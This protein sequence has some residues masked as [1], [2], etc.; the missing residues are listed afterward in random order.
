MNLTLS[1][2]LS[3][4]FTVL[5]LA[6]FGASAWLQVR[7]NAMH[8]KEVVQGLS[9]GL[10]KSIALTTQVMGDDGLQPVAVRR[11]FDQLMIVNPSVEVYLLDPSGRV[12]AHAAP[13]G[14]LKRARVNL[15]PV[16]SL[17]A[18]DMLPILGDDP[19]SASGRKVFSAAV[20]RSGRVIRRNAIRP[21]M[22]PN[23][24]TTAIDHSVM[25]NTELAATRAAS[26]SC[27]S[28]RKIT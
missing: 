18:G 3:L 23:R 2:R 6:S 4:V 17:L 28:T 26:R 11:M 9:R 19:R 1:Q 20:L 27:S 8:E 5:L 22:T 16:R 13:A 14:H 12:T 10:A 21:A 25:R 15:A 24:A 7:A